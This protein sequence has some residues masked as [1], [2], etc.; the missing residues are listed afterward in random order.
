M[1]VELIWITN[2]L[3]II[4]NNF[5]NLKYFKKSLNNIDFECGYSF[6][7]FIQKQNNPIQNIVTK[8]FYL[9]ILNLHETL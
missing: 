7:G 9:K 8:I 3:N 6:W 1:I 5:T 2:Y 4:R